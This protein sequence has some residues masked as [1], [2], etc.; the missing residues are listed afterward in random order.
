LDLNGKATRFKKKNISAII[1]ANV[2]RFCRPDQYGRGFRHTHYSRP[3]NPPADKAG[4]RA[5]PGRPSPQVCS[6]V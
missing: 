6:G 5:G 1:I 3:G 4:G 2:T